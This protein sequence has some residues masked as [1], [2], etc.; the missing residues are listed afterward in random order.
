MYGGWVGKGLCTALRIGQGSLFWSTCKRNDDDDDDNDI[1]FTLSSYYVRRRAMTCHF[2][3]LLSKEM[4]PFI[5]IEKQ[6]QKYDPSDLK[7]NGW[8]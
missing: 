6:L 3:G 4:N 1:R 7:H 2:E 5:S 8:F